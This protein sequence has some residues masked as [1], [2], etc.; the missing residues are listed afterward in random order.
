MQRTVCLLRS[1][2]RTFLFTIR[3][4]LYSLFKM[5]V[6]FFSALQITDTPDKDM[7]FELVDLLLQN[8]Y[9][10]Y[11]LVIGARLKTDYWYGWPDDIIWKHELQDLV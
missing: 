4:N 1:R 10:P 5:K 9:Q 6:T 3:L 11:S 8:G 2:L 7:V